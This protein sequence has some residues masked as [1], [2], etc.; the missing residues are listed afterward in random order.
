[1]VTAGIYPDVF[2]KKLYMF[3]EFYSVKTRPQLKWIFKLCTFEILA[4]ACKGLT[5]HVHAS[6]EMNLF[7]SEKKRTMKSC[8]PETLATR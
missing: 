6:T 4:F 3:Y 2:H 8:F 5:H 1:M 7:F